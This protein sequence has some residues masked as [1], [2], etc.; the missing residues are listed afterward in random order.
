MA[1]RDIFGLG[2]NSEPL[3][4]RGAHPLPRDLGCLVA[5][6][7]PSDGNCLFHAVLNAISDVY[8]AAAGSEER[9]AVVVAFRCELAEFLAAPGDGGRSVYETLAQ[10]GLASYAQTMAANAATAADREEAA[11]YTLGG[12]QEELRAAGRG[13]G[14]QYIELISR[15]VGRNV[16]ILYRDPRGHL[17]PFVTQ[18]ITRNFSAPAVNS[19]ILYHTPTTAAVELEN[20]RAVGHYELAARLAEGAGGRAT[21]QTEFAPQDELVA[22]IHARLLQMAPETRDAAPPAPAAESSASAEKRAPEEP[23]PPEET[24]ET[25]ESNVDLRVFVAGEEILEGDIVLLQQRRPEVELSWAA[26]DQSLDVVAIYREDVIVFLAVDVRNGNLELGQRILSL[27][28]VLAEGTYTVVIYDQAK[29]GGLASHDGLPRGL[30]LVEILTVAV[31]LRR[32]DSLAFHVARPRRP[33]LPRGFR[34]NSGVGQGWANSRCPTLRPRTSAGRADTADSG[35]FG[36]DG[37][38]ACRCRHSHSYRYAQS[39]DRHRHHYHGRD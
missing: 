18:D 32:L 10:G 5:I 17:A 16:Y 11:Q 19:I 35:G 1:A 33:E 7:T 12:M 6:E 38:D 2:K 28:P 36:P 37:N 39:R 22:R 8:R 24:A 15:F 23:P 34:R 9:A 3:L 31:G 26:G 13:V 30:A 27:P 21:H 20:P 4:E 29:I 14:Q 25:E